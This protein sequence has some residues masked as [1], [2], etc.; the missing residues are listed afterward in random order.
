MAYRDVQPLVY[1]EMRKEGYDF[2]LGYYQLNSDLLWKLNKYAK[3]SNFRYN[4]RATGKSYGRAFYDSMV[5]YH[6]K[7]T[8]GVK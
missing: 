5:R 8:K 1:S 2:K 4:D 3:M 6:D 7:R